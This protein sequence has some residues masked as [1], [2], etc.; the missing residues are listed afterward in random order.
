VRERN[1]PTELKQRSV[2]SLVV[3]RDHNGD[4]VARSR[5]VFRDPYK[6]PYGLSL[7]VN[8]QIPAGETREHRVPIGAAAGVVDCEL[9]FKLYYPIEDHHPDLSRLLESR[10]LPFDGLEPST[11][12]VESAPD[13]RIVVPEGIDPQTASP[14]DLV[15]F[16]RP[17]IGQVDVEVPEGDAA[18]DIRKL[19]DLFQ[20][21][22]P[23]ANVLA[24]KR[25]AKI[26][27]KAVPQLI[28]ALGSW[29]NKTFNQAKKVL[30]EIGAD[31]KP[32]VIEA[33]GH[34]QL[35]VRFHAREILAAKGWR[36]EAGVVVGH[37]TR[38][39]TASNAV[40]RCS[41]A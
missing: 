4:E 6:R 40:D 37:L 27:A 25:L 31:A 26:G 10:R 17:Q 28:E 2:E 16:A 41:A 35:Y 33:L 13:V 19:I 14:A 3:V 29:D 22:V 24:R 1:F 11:K 38:G 12:P 36:D 20:F 8:T 21:P 39:L 5:M 30:K 23:E 7:P 18:E 32:A 9:H 34:E 15:D